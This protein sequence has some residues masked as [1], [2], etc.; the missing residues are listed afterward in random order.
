MKNKKAL[1]ALTRTRIVVG[2]RAGIVE[3][4]LIAPPGIHFQTHKFSIMDALEAGTYLLRTDPSKH[5]E[6]FIVGYHFYSLVR[7]LPHFIAENV[8]EGMTLPKFGRLV[9]VGKM[10]NREVYLDMSKHADNRGILT[11]GTKH[12]IIKLTQKVYRAP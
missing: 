7:T 12:A 2:D 1:K 11:N 8:P 9:K 3:W 10:S 5:L 6:T 4:N